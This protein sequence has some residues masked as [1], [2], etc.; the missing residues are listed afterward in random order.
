MSFSDP[1]FVEIYEQID[2]DRTIDLEFYRKIAEEARGKVLEAGCGSGRI[3]LKLLADGIDIEGFDPSEPMLQVLL[4]RAEGLGL[5]AT[6]WH[7]VFDSIE[8]DYAAV[9]SPF[10]SIMHLLEQEE[11][12]AAFVAVHDSLEDGG[13]FAFDVVNP[14]TLDIYDD[15]RQFE[16][17]LTDAATGDVIEIWRQ[18][19]HDPILQV[20]K[21][22]REFIRGRHT[23]HSAIKFR[24]T[25][26]S[27]ISL[28][29]SIAGFSA[30]EVYGGFENEELND[31]STSQVWIARK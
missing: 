29:L 11:Q 30:C 7:G 31:D 4:E 17:S 3:L 5:T 25:Y 15:S 14:H 26:P 6:V 1:A 18:F 8:E 21:Y 28:L 9:I 16:S 12:I 19:E 27:E 10:N 20:G 13:V 24:W 2:G 22:H 23:I